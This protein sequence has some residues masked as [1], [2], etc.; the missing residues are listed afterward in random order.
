[1]PSQ[2]LTQWRTVALRELDEIES[3]HA[4]VGGHARGRRFFTQQINHAYAVLLSSQFQRFCRDLH[5]ESID[6]LVHAINP[7]SVRD[8]VRDSLSSGRRLDRGNVQPNSL[9]EDFERLG[10][11]LWSQTHA[12]GQRNTIRRRHLELLNGW[13]NAIAHQDFKPSLVGG[14]AVLHLGIV[15]QWRRSCDN[16]AKGFDQV[17]CAHLLGVVGVAPWA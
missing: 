1:M 7:S 15:R 16:L 13:R 12:A 9:K 8:I 11:D 17:L 5:S 4:A 6:F 3:A 10:L 14:M 2:S